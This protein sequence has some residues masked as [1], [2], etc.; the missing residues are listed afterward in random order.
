MAVHAIRVQRAGER[1]AGGRDLQGHGPLGGLEQMHLGA[2]AG[3]GLAEL[4]ADGACAQH[5]QALRLSPAGGSPTPQLESS[6]AQVDVHARLR[7]A[8][9]RIMVRYLGAHLAQPGEG[10]VEAGSRL[11]RLLAP[12]RHLE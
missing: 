6:F 2:Q 11:T 10:L 5:C 1:L 12:P 4:G 3:H 9:D 8:L 7:I